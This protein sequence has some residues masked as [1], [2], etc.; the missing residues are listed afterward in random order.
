MNAVKFSR[1]EVSAAEVDY[2]TSGTLENKNTMGKARK[3]RQWQYNWEHV[4][5]VT[6]K[7][8]GNFRKPHN[9]EV[10]K[11]AIEEAAAMFKIG[12]KEFGFGDEDYAHIHMELNIPNTLSMSQVVQIL[13]SHSASRIFQEIPGFRKLYPRGSFWG[14]QYSNSSVGPTNEDTIK[15]YIRKQDISKEENTRQKRLF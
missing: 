1:S 11:N 12:I 14:G 2:M 5:F 6:N 10:T 15:N 7:R 8:K 9:R 4:V 13:K 3:E